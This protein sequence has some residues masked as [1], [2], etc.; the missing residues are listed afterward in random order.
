MPDTQQNKEI[1]G[2]VFDVFRA[3]TGAF[4]D[5]IAED[6]VQHNPQVPN[7]LQPVKEYF[8]SAG[9]VDVEV[10]R[11]IA[12]GDLVAVHSH[13]KTFTLAGVDIFRVGE[14]G[15]IVEHWDVLQE[16]PKTTASGNDMFAQLT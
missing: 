13:Y 15:K 12:E 14:Q 2:R 11:V 8:A 7:G 10:Q 5:L 16:V 4:D 9:P 3:G 6:Y 1:V